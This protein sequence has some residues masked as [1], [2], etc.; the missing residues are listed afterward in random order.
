M[1]SEQVRTFIAVEFPLELKERLKG[2]Q[3][4]LKS[5]G[6][7]FVKWVDPELTHLTLKFLGN[8]TPRQ[9]EIVKAVLQSS[10]NGTGPFT[11]TTGQTGCFPSWR[12]VRVYW[13]GLEGD[14][15]K[16]V[17]LQSN[18]EQAL[19][20]EGYTRDPRPFAAHITLARLKDD[21]T[22][23]DRL[24][25]AQMVQ[26][27]RFMPDCSFNIDH[28]TL[29]KSSLT[30]AGPVYSKLAEYSLKEHIID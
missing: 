2:F 27:A 24:K 4:A 20:K 5:P 22:M 23:Q 21:C 9:L 25:F 16:L 15:R 8:Q 3:A 28:I 7:G 1:A 10:A 19:A 11:L 13:L 29:M 6:Q 26:N 18:I 30:P 17:V 12:N 14:S